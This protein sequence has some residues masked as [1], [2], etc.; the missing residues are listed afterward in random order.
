M[1]C[2][3][4][5]ITPISRGEFFLKFCQDKLRLALTHGRGHFREQELEKYTQ[6]MLSSATEILI[7]LTASE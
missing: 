4:L 2:V 7:F 5:S 3:T 1:Q 6:K